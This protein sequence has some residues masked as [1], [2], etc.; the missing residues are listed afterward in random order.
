MHVT[1]S[2][3]TCWRRFDPP[4]RQHFDFNFVNRINCFCNDV[5]IFFSCIMSRCLFW[6][7]NYSGK[8]DIC[9]SKIWIKAGLRIK[10]VFEY[11][12]P[13]PPP[14]SLTP[15]PCH[16]Q[17]LVPVAD[18]GFQKRGP[19]IFFDFFFLPFY[20]NGSVTKIPLGLILTV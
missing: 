4:S 1:S 8:D 18:P 20:E 17:P 7:Q 11:S 16:R 14:L 9:D 5:A 2:T 10:A 13:P 19:H 6:C 3:Y 12:E 15:L